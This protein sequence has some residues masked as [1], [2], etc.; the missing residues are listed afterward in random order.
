MASVPA[1][2]TSTT[3][4]VG[5]QTP[6]AVLNKV[7]TDTIPSAGVATKTTNTTNAAAGLAASVGM[8]LVSAA[9]AL[10]F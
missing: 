1:T 5:K 9:L 3:T 2:T 6:P 10:L 4:V 8:G 7:V